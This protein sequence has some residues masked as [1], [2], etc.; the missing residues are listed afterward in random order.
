MY[1]FWHA[2]S[3]EGGIQDKDACE[4]EIGQITS[5]VGF[6][7]TIHFIFRR[8]YCHLEGLHILSTSHLCTTTVEINKKVSQKPNNKKA[9]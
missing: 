7:E 4:K 9:I 6:L 3:D 2:V 8:K 1:A 5:K